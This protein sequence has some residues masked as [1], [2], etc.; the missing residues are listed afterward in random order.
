M[1]LFGGKNM[2]AVNIISGII[3]VIA[4]VLIILLVL[5]SDTRNSGL[6]SAIGGSADSFFG[7]NGGNT[8]E[9]KLDR[10]TK[11]SVIV[12]FVVALIVNVVSAYLG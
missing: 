6:N 9:A 4:S 7:K 10:I 2:A 11:I 8:R 3:L 12:F 5:F 1:I